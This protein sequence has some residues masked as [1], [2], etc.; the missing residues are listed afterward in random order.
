MKLEEKIILGFFILALQFLIIIFSI[1]IGIQKVREHSICVKPYQIDQWRSVIDVAEGVY[2]IE[3][4]QDKAELEQ[5][6]G[7]ERKWRDWYYSLKRE[8]DANKELE[9]NLLTI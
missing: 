4:A 1:G 7:E 3:D 6:R 2:L 8:T 9:N 5:C